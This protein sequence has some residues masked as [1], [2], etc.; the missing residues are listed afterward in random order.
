MRNALYLSVLLAL[1][2]CVADDAEQAADE[3]FLQAAAINR[4]RLLRNR[5]VIGVDGVSRADVQRLL[6][7]YDS[8][9]ANYREAGKSAARWIMDAAR[10]N[11]LSPIYLVARIETESGLVR[12]GTLHNLSS[13]TGCG[14]PDSA[15]CDPGQAGFGLQVRCAAEKIRGYLTS[16]ATTGS[17]ISGWRVGVG[18]STLDPCWVVPANKVT[19]ALYT[20]TPWVGAYANGCGTSQWGGSS[21]VALLTRRFRTDMEQLRPCQDCTGDIVVDSDNAANDPAVGRSV[22]S[23]NWIFSSATP[24]YRAANYAWATVS[25]VADAAQLWFYIDTP[26]SRTIEATWTAGSNRSSAT[27][28]V[29][30]DADGRRVDVVRVNQ[31]SGGNQ[32]NR[33]G[34]FPLTRGWNRVLV[35]R[36]ASDGDVVVADAIRVR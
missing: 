31:R 28:F 34:S 3:G 16:L 30:I 20:Y 26:G 29:I 1:V 25:P 5:E 9:L 10:A 18:R 4:N 24:G 27:P 21:L 12:S 11:N 15:E 13:A 2:S 8:A 33:L 36:W 19:A 35:S 22:T 23:N 32:W 14:C 17:T 7:H 6:R